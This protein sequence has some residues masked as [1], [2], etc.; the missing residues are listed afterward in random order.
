MVKQEKKDFRVRA[1]VLKGRAQVGDRIQ[2]ECYCSTSH[3]FGN[4]ERMIIDADLQNP[5]SVK[6]GLG[7]DI[8]VS[9]SVELHN[10]SRNETEKREVAANGKVLIMKIFGNITDIHSSHNP[11][12]EEWIITGNSRIE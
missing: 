5:K 10:D 8:S 1:G 7:N 2:V 11:G 9:A 12:Y 3:E 4:P 6:I